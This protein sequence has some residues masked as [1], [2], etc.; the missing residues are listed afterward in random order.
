MKLKTG[1]KIYA[2]VITAAALCLLVL[3]FWPG[4]TDEAA[5]NDN[6]FAVEELHFDTPEAAVMHF[7]QG[8]QENDMRTIL[9]SWVIADLRFDFV[10]SVENIG[11]YSS[12]LCWPDQYQLY[13]EINQISAAKSMVLNLKCMIWSVNIPDVDTTQPLLHN[14]PDGLVADPERF[15][16]LLDA[17]SLAG[18]KAERIVPVPIDQEQAK[19]KAERYGAEDMWEVAVLYSLDGQY[20]GGGATLFQTENGW[21]INSLTSSLEELTRN[22]ELTPLTPEE[23]DEFVK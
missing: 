21:K 8:I 1:L 6:M 15:E 23:F 17:S 18:L 19:Q 2:A 4:K 11:G 12:S 22:G 20:Y 9:E 13:H 5:G 7:V 3:C 16:T 10:K 14:T